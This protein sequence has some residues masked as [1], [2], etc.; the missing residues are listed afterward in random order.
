MFSN[1]EKTDI[2][3]RVNIWKTGSDI[4]FNYPI[5]GVG[6]GN[7]IYAAQHLILNPL[8]TDHIAHNTLISI[9]A[10]SGTIGLICFVVFL[11]QII[12]R[13]HKYITKNNLFA[14]LILTILVAFF[15]QG[16]FMNIDNIRFFWGVIALGSNVKVLYD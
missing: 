16:L 14:K 15:I 1:S 12:F 8:H 10:E 3:G 9:W 13:L 4:I 5:F 11:T 7:F 2:S 6:K